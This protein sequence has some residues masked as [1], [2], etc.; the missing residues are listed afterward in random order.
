MSRFLRVYAGVTT[1]ICV[2]VGA[3]EIEAWRR[4]GPLWPLIVLWLWGS[5]SFATAMAPVLR[6]PERWGH[7][8][9]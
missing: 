6:H 8:G 9:T 2:F 4:G 3:W 1:L 5:F 7:D